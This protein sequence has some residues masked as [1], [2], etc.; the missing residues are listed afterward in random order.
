[1]NILNRILVII[2]SI[3]LLVIIGAILLVTT[4]ILT[5]QQLLVSPWDL[6]LIAFTQLGSPSWWSVM[7]S[8]IGLAIFSVVLL[9]LEL[10]PGS[11]KESKL[12]V[13]KDDLGEVTAAMTS[14]Q[15]LASRETG[16]ID[17]VMES[18]AQI[19]ESPEGLQIDCRLSV[20]PSVSISDLGRQVQERL[21][22]SI[23][24]YLGRPVA[25]VH[26]T[27]QVAPL[28]NK[29]NQRPSRVR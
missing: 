21:K 25:E 27:A 15:D 19:R 2:G 13:K 1:M 18:F 9:F 12:L 23:E 4:G 3:V 17:G 20:D 14:I 29:H 16:N 26:V 8:G 7:A 11:S 10:R 5:P 24:H 22:I 28:E 6:T